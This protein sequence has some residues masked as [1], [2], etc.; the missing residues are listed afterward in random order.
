VIAEHVCEKL[1][2]HQDAPYLPTI[3]QQDPW[4]MHNVLPVEKQAQAKIQLA[5]ERA[6]ALREAMRDFVSRVTGDYF[7][8]ESARWY[9]DFIDPP[10]YGPYN[11]GDEWKFFIWRNHFV[12]A[13]HAAPHGI[14]WKILKWPEIPD[15]FRDLLDPVLVEEDWED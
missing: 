13:F 15:V 10:L 9:G 6:R 4:S 7:C 5:R 3:C 2:S 12:M 8:I 1:L 14:A 11:W